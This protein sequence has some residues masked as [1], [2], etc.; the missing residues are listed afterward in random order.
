MCKRLFKPYSS[1][2][3]SLISFSISLGFCPIF[4]N[5]VCPLIPLDEGVVV[6]SPSV[7]RSLR[8]SLYHL[9]VLG[10]FRRRLQIFSYS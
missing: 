7:S 8:Y 6:I 2:N 1:A 4:I 5:V 10:F 3:L 9:G